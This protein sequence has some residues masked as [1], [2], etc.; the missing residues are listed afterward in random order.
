MID[1]RVLV[2][3]IDTV[4]IDQ[5]GAPLDP[6][7]LVAFVQQQLRKVCAVLSGNAGYQSFLHAYSSGFDRR[8]RAGAEITL[9][10]DHGPVQRA[11]RELVSFCASGKSGKGSKQGK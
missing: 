4:G 5:G 2:D 10:Y 11:G 8:A 7:Y 9:S 3:V 6:V 1:V